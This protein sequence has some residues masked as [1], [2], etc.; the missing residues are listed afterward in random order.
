MRKYDIT[1]CR[2]YS[3]IEAAARCH[4]I[5]YFYLGRRVLTECRD[6]QKKLTKTHLKACFG[7]ASEYKSKVNLIHYSSVDAELEFESCSGLLIFH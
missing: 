2:C 4:Y 7:P 5:I 6:S 1:V 3:I